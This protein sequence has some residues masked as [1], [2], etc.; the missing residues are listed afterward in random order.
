MF[1][2]SKKEAEEILR[3][4]F[5]I[6][7]QGQHIKHLPY[8]FTEQG[9]AMASGI[10]KSKTAIEVNIRIMR[11]F[12]E[13]RRKISTHPQYESLDQ[14]LKEIE[15]KLNVLDANKTVDDLNTHKKITTLSQKV[16][17]ITQTLDELQNAYVIVQKPGIS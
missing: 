8:A 7:K 15:S 14:K 3:S 2:L 12:V 16:Q 6:L 4:H 17:A 9:I 1:Q 11:T 10:L 13:L 5:A